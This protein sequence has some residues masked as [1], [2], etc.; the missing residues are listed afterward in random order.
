MQLEYR[1]FFM[2]R[3]FASLRTFGWG[4]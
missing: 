3:R 1:D 4:E 2:L